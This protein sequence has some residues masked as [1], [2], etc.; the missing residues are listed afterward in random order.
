M[1]LKKTLKKLG[2]A[3]PVIVANAPAIA[4]AVR[5]VREALKKPAPARPDAP[6][7]ATPA[8]RAG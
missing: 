3:I 2:K 5:Q 8:D 1:G 7:P 4:D 6:A